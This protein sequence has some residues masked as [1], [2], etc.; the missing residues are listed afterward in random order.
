MSGEESESLQSK[1]LMPRVIL[2]WKYR[3][4]GERES[5]AMLGGSDV[6]AET[7]QERKQ[8]ETSDRKQV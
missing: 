8:E 2:G 7:G 1:V 6:G 4:R 3:T 5:Q